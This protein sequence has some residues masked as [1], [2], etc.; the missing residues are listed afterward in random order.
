[1]KLN[2]DFL[3]KCIK[4]INNYI[5]KPSKSLFSF[6]LTF[7]IP[8]GVKIIYKVTSQ[9]FTIVKRETCFCYTGARVR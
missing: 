1:M 5:H 7:E 9:Q 2:N 3:K 4:K 6:I 8:T